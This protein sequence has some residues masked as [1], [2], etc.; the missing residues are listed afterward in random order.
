MLLFLHFQPDEQKLLES[1]SEELGV[2]HRCRFEPDLEMLLDLA[3]GQETQAMRAKFPAVIFLDADA[4]GHFDVLTSLKAHHL[5]NRIPVVCLGNE[6]LQAEVVRLY[7][8]GANSYI[9][10]PGDY[11]TLVQVAGTAL[12][13]WL[14]TTML[15]QEHLREL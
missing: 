6:K 11:E 12:N 5:L 15:P 1:A 14:E 3:K 2:A 7:E 13:Y 4:E 10:K 8:A 9:K